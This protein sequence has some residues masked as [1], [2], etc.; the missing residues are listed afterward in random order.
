MKKVAS[1]VMTALLIST[2]SGCTNRN[3]ALRNDYNR[4]MHPGTTQGTRTG[5]ETT[6]QGRTQG[7]YRDG[8]YTGTGNPGSNGNQI[9][10][11]T[12]SGGKI[13]DV[14]L[15]S[16]DTQGKELGNNTVPPG[17]TIGK[18]TGNTASTTADTPGT[19]NAGT[20]GVTTGGM[21][22]GMAGDITG[23]PRGNTNYAAGDYSYQ[24]YGGNSG[25]MPGSMPN[26]ISG[27]T[28]TGTTTGGTTTNFGNYDQMKREIAS[29]VI[30]NQTYDINLGRNNTDMG[31]NWKLAVRRALEQAK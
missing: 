22:G 23:T 8:V 26:G 6:N 15:R 2:L 5:Y 19:R 10:T 7:T 20:P 18:I 25:P 1:L 21:A 11:V 24:G 12:I 17:T 30:N 13:I 3:T 29:S 28:N 31:Q 9:A 27:R 4:V 16:V 14:A